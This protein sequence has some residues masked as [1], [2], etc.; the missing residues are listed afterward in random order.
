MG[1]CGVTGD[2]NVTAGNC[3]MCPPGDSIRIYGKY[4]TEISFSPLY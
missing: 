1:W 4:F 2:N 3:C